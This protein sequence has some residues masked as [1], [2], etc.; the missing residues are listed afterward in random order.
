MRHCPSDKA[1]V[2]DNGHDDQVS[3]VPLVSTLTMVAAE[4]P[5]ELGALDNRL[6]AFDT[7]LVD[8]AFR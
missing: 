6:P 2:M 5:P 4:T 3:V 1:S 8:G 7:S